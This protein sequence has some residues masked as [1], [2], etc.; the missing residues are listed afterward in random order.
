MVEFDP[1]APPSVDAP[2]PTAAGGGPL[3]TDQQVVLATFFG[4]PI[5]GFILLGINEG[6]L[7]RPDKLNRTVAIGVVASVA[8]IAIALVLPENFPGFILSLAYLLGMQQLARH[9]QGAEIA[10]QLSNGVAKASGWAAFG[11]GVACLAGVMVVGGVY[12]L[13]FLM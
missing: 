2:A 5:A 4:T 13:L 9:W 8:V 3:F 7:G 10:E 11:V 6:R 1:Y 12:G